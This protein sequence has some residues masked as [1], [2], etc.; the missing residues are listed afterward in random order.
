MKQQHGM[1]VDHASTRDTVT[2]RERASVM[3][4]LRSNWTVATPLVVPWCIVISTGSS[5]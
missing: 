4:A 2:P 1:S 5:R 3:S